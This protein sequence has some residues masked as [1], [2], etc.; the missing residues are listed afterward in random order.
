MRE[1]QQWVYGVLWWMCGQ[2][3]ACLRR[4]GVRLAHV[5]RCQRSL[6]GPWGPVFKVRNEDSFVAIARGGLVS[7]VSRWARWMGIVAGASRVAE[8]GVDGRNGV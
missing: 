1:Q 6:C 8:S 3:C 7:L 5:G 2:V 4:K